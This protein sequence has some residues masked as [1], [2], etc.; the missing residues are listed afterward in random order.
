MVQSRQAGASP[1]AIGR[2]A[3][4]VAAVAA[5]V[6]GAG[7]RLLAEVGL[8]RPG[9]TG[10]ALFFCVSLTPSLLPR[11]WQVQG[12]ISGVSASVDYATGVTLAWLWRR[13]IRRRL[14]VAHLPP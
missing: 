12:L 1:R 2:S 4:L 7:A 14:P 9:M 5:R 11:T 3:A 6:V 13:I 10:A 8:S